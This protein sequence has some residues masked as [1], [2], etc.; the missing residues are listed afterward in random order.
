MIHSRSGEMALISHQMDAFDL[1]SNNITPRFN[2]LLMFATTI[3]S[4]NELLAILILDIKKSVHLTL[5]L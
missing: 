1:I 3:N 5:F 2:I 4:R